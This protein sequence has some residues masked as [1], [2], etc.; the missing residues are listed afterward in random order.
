MRTIRTLFWVLLLF[1]VWTNGAS[2]NLQTQINE[3]VWQ[4]KFIFVGTIVRHNASTLSV[5][6]DSSRTAVVQVHEVIDG[7]ESLGDYSGKQITVLLEDPDKKEADKNL[8]FFTNGWLY[9]KSIAVIEVG[10]IPWNE[11]SERVKRQIEEEV[12]KRPDRALMLRLAE[13]ELVIVGKVEQ[14]KKES[15]PDHVQRDREHD[16]DWHEAIIR[17]IDFVKGQSDQKTIRLFYPNSTDVRW[18]KSPK[19]RVSQEGIWILRRKEIGEYTALDP[20]DFQRT[21]QLERIRRLLKDHK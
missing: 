17:V 20:M 1:S 4:S 13:A 12:K 7:P 2:Q 11:E 5:I 14:T 10:S 16:P 18:Y 3:L 8:I 15:P 19:F 9:G 6:Q 21:D